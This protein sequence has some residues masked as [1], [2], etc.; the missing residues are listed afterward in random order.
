MQVAQELLGSHASLDTP[1]MAAGLDS[2]GAVEFCSR[3]SSHL[4][5]R[6]PETLIFDFPTL[7]QVEAHVD[8]LVAAASHTSQHAALPVSNSVRDLLS[9]LINTERKPT[10]APIATPPTGH[11]TCI[12]A[13]SC[14]MGGG[15]RGI[16][17]SWHA[18]TTA[19]DAVSSAPAARWDA[20]NSLDVRAL[21]GAFVQGIDLFDHVA[22]GLAP[23]EA[24]VMDPHQRLALE[25]GYL[26]L[27]ATGFD[28]SSLMNSITGVFGGLW[29]SDYSTVLPKRG[30]LGRGPFAVAAT[31]PAMLVGR[32]S[33]TLGMQGPSIAFDTAC[34]ASLSAFQAAMYAQNHRDCEAALVL[35]VNVM[36]DSG[37][38]QLFAAAQMTSPTGKSHTFD[39]RAN[40]YARG[41][42]CCCVALLP[43]S[44][45]L[46]RVRCEAGAVRQDGKSASLTAPNGTAQQA[47]ARAALSSAGR[48]P[49]GAFVLEAHGTGTSLGDPIEARAMCAVRDEPDL[50]SVMGCKANVGHTEPTAGV[51][52][53]LQLAIAMRQR[54]G[55][56]NAQLRIMNS[57]VKAAL[58]GSPFLPVHVESIWTAEADLVGGVSSF[59]LNGTIAH[60]IVSTAASCA[61][62]IGRSSTDVLVFGR[63]RRSDNNTP[64]LGLSSS[65]DEVA[66]FG[67]RGAEAR[68]GV[69]TLHPNASTVGWGAQAAGRALM[70][71]CSQTDARC[72]PSDRCAR[73]P[74]FFYRRRAFP[75]RS[76]TTPQPPLSSNA[77]AK[78]AEVFELYFASPGSVNNLVIRPQ[79]LHRLPMLSD[80]HV[81]LKV[82]AAGL[83]FRD[84]LNMLDLDPTRTVRPLGLEC[85]SVVSSA[86]HWV[87]HMCLDD[88][89]YGMAM[90]C[91][92]SIVRTDARVQA[93]MPRAIS[94]EEACTLPILWCTVALGVAE[95]AQ[96]DARQRVLIHATT[97]GVGLVALEFAHR[98]GAVVSG[99]VGRPSKVAHLRGVGV[100]SVA[101]SRQAITFVRGAA[102]CLAGRRLDATLSAL[103]KGFIP[104]T[105]GVMHDGSRYLEVGKNNIWSDARMSAAVACSPFRLVAADF[106]SAKWTLGRL[107]E[108]SERVRVGEVHPL[109]LT[110][111][112]FET[113]EMVRAFNELRRGDHIGRYVPRYEWLGL[114]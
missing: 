88:S 24:D 111:F 95:C 32:L 12:H 99:S 89:V 79:N 91:L 109:P 83:N 5:T 78:A 56:P 59:G 87:S 69:C 61:V 68:G 112:R 98:V 97:G 76:I 102:S 14:K 8:T 55:C 45:M 41:E 70:A 36:C 44:E 63:G 104:T 71:E 22:F 72:S 7:R 42:A 18:G 106:Q 84:V 100:T 62:S 67:S 21:Y 60:V 31:G 26:A 37:V 96:L 1:L 113:A 50:M 47:L 80:G 6:L 17:A 2:L 53:L 114:L 82:Q 65:L 110:S 19:H 92:A 93:H 25:E 9:S 20:S 43:E 101:S 3:L 46:R 90:G 94:F 39:A 74:L 48:T 73:S 66:A 13:A 75:W 58:E 30:A 107:G 103:T 16:M 38:S 77:R 54:L 11:P 108:L 105:L 4:S 33:Y 35:G 29:P 27:H 85:S 57:H 52:G 86:G 34:S 49:C 64:A 28:R 15:V 51:A 23:A 40:G 10:S 81:E